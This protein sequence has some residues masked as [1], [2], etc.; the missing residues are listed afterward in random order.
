MNQ[1]KTFSET[2]VQ[3][4][5]PLTQ[6]F[7]L[8][9][10]EQVQRLLAIHFTVAQLH[11]DIEFERLER[12]TLQFLVFQLQKDIPFIQTLLGNL[13]TGAYQKPFTIDSPSAATIASPS[14]IETHE[15][16]KKN[17]SRHALMGNS[18]QPSS[19]ALSSF[20]DHRPLSPEYTLKTPLKCR[21]DQLEK[22]LNEEILATKSFLYGLQRT[23]T[24]L[25]D[26]IRQLES[27][28]ANTFLGGI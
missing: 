23:Y 24:F 6:K 19:F 9:H 15:L 8:V 28:I 25:F 26:K 22:L 27:G 18:D 17:A 1:L 3:Q 12:Q 10:L 16:P 11:Q 20:S 2:P 5:T 4:T 14:T 21:V 7:L 13:N